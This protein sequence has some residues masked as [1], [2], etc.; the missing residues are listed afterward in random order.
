M[1]FVSHKFKSHKINPRTEILMVG[2]FNPDILT[3]PDFFYG[4][5]RNYLWQ[6]LPG[7][8][9]LPSLK[10][11]SLSAKEQF[12][13]DYKIDFVDLIDTVAV[14]NNQV[15]NVSDDFIDSR[16]YRWNGILRQLPSLRRLKALYF[17]RKTFENIPNIHS[18]IF[19]IMQYCRRKNIRFCLLHS[20]AR[21]GRPSKQQEWIDTIVIQKTCLKV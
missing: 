6:L 5:G 15:D 3:G 19:R 11:A 10:Q 13:R 20:P 2:T 12:M 16:I 9:G 18:R 14:P 21:S 4:R 8:W 17:T 1:V 7:C